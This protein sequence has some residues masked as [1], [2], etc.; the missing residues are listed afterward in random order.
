MILSQPILLIV[1]LYLPAMI[2]NMAPVFATKYNLIPRLNTAIDFG[3]TIRGKRV[4]GENKTLR[5]FVVGICAAGITGALLFFVTRSVPYNSFFHAL[6]YGATT[7]CGALA[8]DSVKSFFKRRMNMKP[9]ELWIPFDQIDFVI[10][11]T[12]AALFFID[13]SFSMFV[14]AIIF[15]GLLSYV[16]SKI[17]FALH[18]KKNL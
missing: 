6:V 1:L 13:I 10:G 18:I 12:V 9:G 2:A 7:G 16:V 8:G 3:I 17:G 14:V 5:G 15:I 11:A 4:L